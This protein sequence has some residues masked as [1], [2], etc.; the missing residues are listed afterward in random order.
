MVEKLILVNDFTTSEKEQKIFT[1]QFEKNKTKCKHL[2][3]NQTDAFYYIG[4][5]KNRCP[6]CGK[7][8]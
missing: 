3:P 1:H 6:I 7:I 4:F 8:F 2:Y 5:G